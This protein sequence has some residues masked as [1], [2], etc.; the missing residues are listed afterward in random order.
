VKFE[1]GI[2][3][4]FNGVV[5]VSEED[6]QIMRSEYELQNVLGAVPTGVDVAHFESVKRNPQPNTIAFLGSMDWMPNIDA[7]KFFVQDIFPLLRRKIHDLKLTIIGRNPPPDVAALAQK[8][9]AIRVTGTV[10]DVRPFLAEAHALIVPLRVGGG[11]RIK[12]FEAIAAGIPVVSTSIGMEGL[13]L[14]NRET[15]LVADSPADFARAIEEILKNP[16][17]AE[18]ISAAARTLVRDR[19]SWEAVTDIFSNYC[20]RIVRR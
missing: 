16:S 17:F 9:P 4:R 10:P 20:H 19:F 15:I 5:G 8:D 18:K 3:A 13:P 2:S 7:I 1:S 6:C 12:I 11:T 14:Q